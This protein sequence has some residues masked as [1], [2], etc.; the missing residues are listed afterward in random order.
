[1]K[2]QTKHSFNYNALVVGENNK[3]FKLSYNLERKVKM[4]SN[5]KFG[6]ATSVSGFTGIKV[7]SLSRTYNVDTAEARNEKGQVID[8]ATYG[9]GEEISVDGL[10]TGTGVKPGSIIRLDNKNYLVTAASESE[11]NTAFVTQN[12]TARYAPDCEL[13]W[14]TTSGT[15]C[16]QLSTLNTNAPL[17]A[18]QAISG[19]MIGAG[20]T[21]EGD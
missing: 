16:D 12:A 3:Y 20:T 18:Y 8:I 4:A 7:N 21:T 15:M 13:W 6:I 19:Q 11:S 9:N 17:S 2:L 10:T 5:R 14:V 1:M